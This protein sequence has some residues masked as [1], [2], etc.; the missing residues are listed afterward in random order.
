MASLGFSVCSIMA[1]ANSKRFTSSFPVWIPC[2]SF[3]LVAVDRI[4]KTMLNNSG[5]SGHPHLV[6][7]V[8]EM[9]S[10]F[11]KLRIMFAVGLLY[12]WGLSWWLRW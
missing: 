5:E 9:L 7:D 2:I 3:S 10:V 1:S 11:Q 8:K 4:S 6:P 12:I